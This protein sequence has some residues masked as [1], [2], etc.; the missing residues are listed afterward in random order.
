MLLLFS[1]FTILISYVYTAEFGEDDLQNN[2]ENILT[3]SDFNWTEGSFLPH[4]ETGYAEPKTEDFSSNITESEIH[5]YE[6]SS[7]YYHLYA[8]VYAL[9]PIS[10]DITEI[11]FEASASS[12]RYD[13][14]IMGV[15]IIDPITMKYLGVKRPYNYQDT[16]ISTPHDTGFNHFVYTF[17]TEGYN[18]VFLFFFYIDATV[19]YW[20]QSIRV[21]NLALSSDDIL[22][23]SV[24]GHLLFLPGGEEPVGIEWYV[25]DS[26]CEGHYWILVNDS[27]IIQ[28]EWYSSGIEVVITFLFG[29][30]TPAFYNFTIAVSDKY[31]NISVDT[32]IC[33]IRAEEVITTTPDQND[34]LTIPYTT[35][36]NE[37]DTLPDTTIISFSSIIWTIFA[38]FALTSIFVSMKKKR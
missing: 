12:S 6:T 33:E 1:S 16:G 5:V 18:E 20:E 24:H 8:G 25:F 10:G 34:T 30:Y 21:R 32:I 29:D 3:I 37:S 22:P 15:G 7:S 17:D 38:L 11:N 27:L 2:S 19:A 4:Y 9:I 14:V 31:E 35:T 28:D 23:P 13:Q 26:S 36:P